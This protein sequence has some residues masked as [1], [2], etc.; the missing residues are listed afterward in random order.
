MLRMHAAGDII[1]IIFE[2]MGKYI[3]LYEY[4]YT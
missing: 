1:F 3:C 4:I 2:N